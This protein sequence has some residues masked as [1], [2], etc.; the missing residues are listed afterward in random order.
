MVFVLLGAVLV[1]LKLA[2]LNPVAQWSWFLA[3]SPFALAVAWWVWSDS[4]G[5][6]Q[7]QAMHKDRT[8]KEARRRNLADGLGLRGMF[9]RGVSAKLRKA[10]EKEQAARQRKIDKIERER[11]RIRQAN[12]DSILTTRMDSKFDSR[13]DAPSQAVDPTNQT[14]ASRPAR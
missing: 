13:F 2:E 7:R 11:E 10:E 1:A 3:L 9:D 14:E 5:R 4:S 8:R 12:R 6:T